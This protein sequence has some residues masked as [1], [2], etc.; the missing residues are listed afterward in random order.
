MIFYGDLA[1]DLY[2]L[3][4]QILSPYVVPNLNYI[5]RCFIFINVWGGIGSKNAKHLFA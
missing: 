5:R 1:V 2:Y 3:M 4:K